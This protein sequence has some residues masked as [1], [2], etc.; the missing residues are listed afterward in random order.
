MLNWQPLEFPFAAGLNQKPDPRLVQ[1]PELVRAVDVD[2]TNT[3]GL[4]LR[5]PYA[6]IGA[7]ILGGGTISGTRR[8]YAIGTELLLFTQTG[9]YSWSPQRSAWVMK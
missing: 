5:Y 2:F 6:S 3:G 8:V 1:A 4:Q 9:F 7:N